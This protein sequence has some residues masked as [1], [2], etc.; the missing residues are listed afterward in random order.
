MKDWKTTVV[1]ILTLLGVL[2]VA[3]KSLLT[4]GFGCVDFKT[5]VEAIVAALVGWGLVKAA[6]SQP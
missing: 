3:G 1:G 5:V 6:D 4:C 2:A